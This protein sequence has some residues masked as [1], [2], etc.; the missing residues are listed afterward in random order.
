MQDFWS[1]V[2]GTGSAKSRAVRAG[3]INLDQ[4]ISSFLEQNAGAAREAFKKGHPNYAL[5]PLERNQRMSGDLMHLLSLYLQR[6]NTDLI[7]RQIQSVAARGGR[8]GYLWNNQVL[9]AEIQK[10]G[11]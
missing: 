9:R 11:K 4:L 5:T 3:F 8:G 2:S 7:E 1:A 6:S 10:L